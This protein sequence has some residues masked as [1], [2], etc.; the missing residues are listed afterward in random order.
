MEKA[1]CDFETL[2]LNI[3]SPKPTAN[4][5]QKPETF[6]PLSNQ[7]THQSTLPS[8]PFKNKPYVIM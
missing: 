8:P 2:N 7:L 5:K 1:E 3:I 6:D 4:I